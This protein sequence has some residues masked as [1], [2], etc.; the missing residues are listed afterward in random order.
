MPSPTACRGPVG[1]LAEV[2]D[3]RYHVA[4]LA[5]VFLALIIGILVGVG[6]SGSGLVKES[7]RRAL[8][9]QI[10]G[11]Q[12]ELASER[13]RSREL[14]GAETFVD[15]AYGAVMANRLAGRKIALVFVGSIDRGVRTAVARAVNDDAGGEI[16]RLRAL[17]VPLRSE[18][19]ETAVASRPALAS[20]RNELR[21]LGRDLGRELVSGGQTPL[22]DALS[23][24]LVEERSGGSRDAVD[25]V[26]VMRTA[27]PQPDPTGGFLLG[28]Y[29]GLRAGV[30]VVGVET[31]SRP[32][33]SIPLYRRVGFSSVDDVD[34]DEGKVA[35]AVLL[36][37]G[38]EGHYGLRTTAEGVVPPIEPVPAPAGAT[39]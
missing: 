38:R 26:V 31:T 23:P 35:L 5:A 39:G 9:R 13:E 34:T 33:S 4:S 17:A 25:A 21:N 3:L 22:W 20:Y 12:D 36:A 6:M 27:P 7:E 10:E 30:P 32:R 2:F 8:E 14:E 28:F 15:A 19:V 11:L 24:A 1:H 29:A 37:G 16:I 18:A